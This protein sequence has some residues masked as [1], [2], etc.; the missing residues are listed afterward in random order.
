M[1]LA[2]PAC[3][4]RYDVTGHAV[5]QKFRCRCGEMMTLERAPIEAGELACP[6]CGAGVAPT[7][8]TC[9][10]CSHELLLKACPRCLTRVFHG[11]KHCPECGSELDIAA[12]THTPS[13][14]ICPRCDRGLHARRVGEIDCIV[15]DECGACLGVFLDHIAIKRVI[16]DRARARAEALLGALPRAEL[17]ALPTA[18]QKMY[19]KCPI[20]RTV[21]NRKLFATGAGVIVDVCRTH[22][23]FFDVGELPQIIDFVM[24]GGLEQAQKKDIARLR[25]QARQELAQAQNASR[26]AS[27]YTYSEYAQRSHALADLLSSIWY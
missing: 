3:D 22:G 7:A 18:G 2:C 16:T 9:A 4:S 25:E 10:Y 5:G 17:H 24:N 8:S 12:T 20:C 15:V 1:I 11:H 6:H 23:T 21:M 27:R 19:L 26:E 14:R 13:E